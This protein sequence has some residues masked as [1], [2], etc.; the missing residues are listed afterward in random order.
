MTSTLIRL[1]RATLILIALLATHQVSSAQQAFDWALSEDAKFDFN[2]FQ[3]LLE[4]KGLRTTT[5]FNAVLSDDPSKAVIVLVGDLDWAKTADWRRLFSFV[6]RGGAL[7]LATDRDVNVQ[8]ICHIKAGP[9]Q[10]SERDAYQGFRDCPVI[11]VRLAR[12]PLTRG[13]TQIVGNRTGWI[14]TTWHALGPSRTIAT[15]PR[16]RRG[17]QAYARGGFIEAIETERPDTGGRL[18]VAADHSLFVNG[19]LLH[20]NNA[21]FAINTVDWLCDQ[22][23]RQRL[24]FNISGQASRSGIPIPPVPPDS[25]PPEAIPDSLEDIPPFS[26]EDLIEAPPESL[27]TFGN[28]LLNG[29]QE[30]NVF[31]QLLA[32]SAAELPKDE[33][34]QQLYVTVAAMAC[35]WLI[36]KLVRRGSQFEASVVRSTDATAESLASEMADSSDLRRPLRE[37][38]QEL[39]RQVTDSDNQD[40]WKLWPRTIGVS[41]FRR[42][43][44]IATGVDQRPISRNQFRKLARTIEHVRRMSEKGHFSADLP[45]ERAKRKAS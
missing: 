21:M 39:F 25:I 8:G 41:G 13:V 14:S 9:V 16:F 35:F 26:V 20:G 12:H 17:S 11:Q 23:D 4:Q 32:H 43:E 30:E 2:L 37:L 34:N 10:V 5:D 19:M 40:D 31:N 28:S 24:Y 22:P 3:L 1:Q 38:A 36:R 7:L 6:K 45:D 44:E 15:L 29:L 33:Y 42:I 27:I 18:L